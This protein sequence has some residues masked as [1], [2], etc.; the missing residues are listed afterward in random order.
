MKAYIFNYLSELKYN[1]TP[2]YPHLKMC[3]IS[4]TCSG[5]LRKMKIAAQKHC[6]K[7][8]VAMRN[9]MP[10]RGRLA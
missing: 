5:I 6:N 8:K 2:A 9:R 3:F 1:N 7:I 4:I 10:T